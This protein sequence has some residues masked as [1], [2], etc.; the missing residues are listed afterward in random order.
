MTADVEVIAGRG[1]C[2]AR[3]T[4]DRKKNPL[5]E[6]SNSR[7]TQEDTRLSPLQETQL[8]SL[9]ILRPDPTYLTIR[10]DDL[11]PFPNRVAEFDL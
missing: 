1:R 9:A 2:Q 5:S 10:Q 6:Y 3:K 4:N 11:D 7:K 8:Y